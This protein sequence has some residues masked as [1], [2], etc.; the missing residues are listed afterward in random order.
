M[1]SDEQLRIIIKNNLGL[2][3]SDIIS[4]ERAIDNIFYTVYPR[5][6][7]LCNFGQQFCSCPHDY[8]KPQPC[9]QCRVSAEYELTN[10]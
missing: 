10:D 6:K 2:Y 5:P 3:K 4:R 7:K 1:T 9:H 8:E